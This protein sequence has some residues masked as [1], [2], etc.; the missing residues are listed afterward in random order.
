MHE[1]AENSAN[2]GAIALAQTM[3]AVRRRV[4]PPDSRREAVARA[5]YMPFVARLQR[6]AEARQQRALQ[7]V[8]PQTAEV[9]QLRGAPQGRLPAA[10]RILLLKLDHIGDFLLG[11]RSV[12]RLRE[13]FPDA[14]F[15]LVCG[16]WNRGWAE[17]TGWFDRVV[18]FDFFPASSGDWDG[19]TEDLYA[20]FVALPLGRFDLAIDFRHDFDTRKLLTLVDAKYRAGYCAMPE[21]GG[22][23]LDLALPGVE[24]ISPETGTGTPLLAEQRLMV[25]ADAVVE[26]FRPLPPHPA[27]TLVDPRRLNPALRAVAERRFIAMAVGTGAPIKSWSLNRF[28]ELAQALLARHEDAVVALIGGPRD[29]MAGAGIAESLPADRVVDLTGEIDLLA[30]PAFLDRA[31]MFVGGDTGMTHLAALL[32]VPTVSVFSGATAVEVWRPVGPR[33]AIVAGK[34]SCSPCHLTKLE[35]CPYNVACLEVIKVSDVL[36]ACDSVGLAARPALV[37]A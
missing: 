14:T 11:M 1:L 33:V 27:R 3:M 16:P 12:E 28:A 26:A 31:A 21:F 29:R 18:T 9:V 25:L 37:A 7:D 13:G 30:M 20:A 4:F 10:P 6:A 22:D 23:R 35:Q 19:A 34:T 15:T 17:A 32:G 36:E 24:H 5:L 8:V 2:S